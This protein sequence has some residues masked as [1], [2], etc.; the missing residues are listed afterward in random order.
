MSDR[1]IRKI[2]LEEKRRAIRAE[3]RATTL[4]I[5]EGA[6]GFGSMF[7]IGFMLTMLG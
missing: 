3:R 2:L 4:G 5:I 7:V 6:L 1:Q